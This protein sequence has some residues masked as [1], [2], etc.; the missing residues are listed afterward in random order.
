MSLSGGYQGPRTIRE[1]VD[2]SRALSPR[3]HRAN[4]ADDQLKAVATD[5]GLLGDLAEPGHIR[6]LVHLFLTGRVWVPAAEA[7]ADASN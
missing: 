3:G 2:Y 7:A 1:L 6:S 4:R 5:Y